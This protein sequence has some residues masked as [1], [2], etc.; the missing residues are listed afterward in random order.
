M[1]GGFWPEGFHPAFQAPY[2][3]WGNV[4]QIQFMNAVSN[5]Q[6]RF[7]VLLQMV[8]SRS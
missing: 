7:W 6:P 2:S 1:K 8:S 3:D 5:W 4:E